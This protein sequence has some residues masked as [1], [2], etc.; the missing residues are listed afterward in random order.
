MPYDTSDPTRRAPRTGSADRDGAFVE[1]AAPPRGGSPS[2]R[3]PLLDTVRGFFHA[4][5][6]CEVADAR[7]SPPGHVPPDQPEDAPSSRPV[8]PLLD[9]FAA[10]HDAGASLDAYDRVQ[11]AYYGDDNPDG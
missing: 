9:A 1:A 2:L 4:D 7:T 10:L 11:R 6:P 8:R 5:P 3:P